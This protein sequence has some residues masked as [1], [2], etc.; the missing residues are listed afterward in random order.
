MDFLIVAK[1]ES[2]KAE[3]LLLEEIEKKIGSAVF[4]TLKLIQ[5]KSGVQN[6]AP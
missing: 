2:Y 1:I 5:E 3:F 6:L 4:V